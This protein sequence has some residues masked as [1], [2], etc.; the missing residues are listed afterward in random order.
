M[1]E[2]GKAK[3]AGVGRRSHLRGYGKRGVQYG[4]QQAAGREE[5]TR[6]DPGTRSVMILFA[7]AAS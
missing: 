5:L 2:N 7:T 6:G 4:E 1:R 3:C